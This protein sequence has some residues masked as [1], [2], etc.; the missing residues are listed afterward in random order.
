MMSRTQITL[1]PETQRLA[2]KRAGELG[3][4]FAEYIRRLVARDLHRPRARADI[5]RIFNLG[6]SG[7]SNIAKDKD[8]MLGE[9]AAAE[10]RRSR[11]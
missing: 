8:R 9:A 2:Q 4:S 7:G 3:V 6:N 5:S 10:H 1:E 11:R